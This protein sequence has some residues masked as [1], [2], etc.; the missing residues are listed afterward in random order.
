MTTEPRHILVLAAPL[1]G[2]QEAVR[3]AA[4]LARPL[5]AELV[6]LGVAPLVAPG[7]AGE[8]DAAKQELVEA[9]A[10]ATLDDMAALVPADVRVRTVL[11]WGP[12]GRATVVAVGEEAADLVVV[13][14]QHA[15]P[16]GHAL[17]DHADR[18]VLHECPVPVLVVPVGVNPY[19]RPDVRSPTR[20][21]A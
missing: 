4:W 19:E 2:G 3:R 12:P 1:P 16:V 7:E 5:G 15:S 6:L 21:A 8:R 10:R 17:H 18:Q 13:P 9:L 14:M 20:R 11:G